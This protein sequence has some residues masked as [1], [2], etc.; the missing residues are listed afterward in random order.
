VRGRELRSRLGNS[1][2][3][4]ASPAADAAARLGAGAGAGAGLG[5][6]PVGQEGLEVRGERGA[7]HVDLL[8]GE[9]RG[10]SD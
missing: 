9:G 1:P 8:R 6:V 10:V 4:R 7:E 3:A 2:A 5:P